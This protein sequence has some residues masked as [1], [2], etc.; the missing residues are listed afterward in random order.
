MKALG[1]RDAEAFSAGA[2]ADHRNTYIYSL[3]HAKPW[4]D[5]F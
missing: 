5:S 1:K 3:I 4:I 2:L